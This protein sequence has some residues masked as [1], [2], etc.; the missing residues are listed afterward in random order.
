MHLSRK[1]GQLVCPPPVPRGRN[2]RSTNIIISSSG[3]FPINRAGRQWSIEW[4]NSFCAAC[5]L[6][7]CRS[8]E[9]S[10][11]D[12][13]VRLCWRRARHNIRR[14]TIAFDTGRRERG[15]TRR[16]ILRGSRFHHPPSASS[17]LSSS[18]TDDDES[19]AV[20]VAAAAEPPPPTRSSPL[21]QRRATVGS[22]WRW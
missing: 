20:L 6:V 8:G 7:C 17:F 13:P 4:H 18:G 16:S 3:H 10:W 15:P 2:D 21:H 1:K 19:F 5:I 9:E 12:A 22:W 14:R 11:M